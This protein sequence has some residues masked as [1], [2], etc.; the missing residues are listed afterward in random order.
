M[1]D[2]YTPYY[3]LRKQDPNTIADITEVNGNFDILDTT[4]KARADE[5]TALTSRVTSLESSPPGAIV[6][7]TC[8]PQAGFSIVAT[9]VRA[10]KRYGV[11]MF[12]ITLT[13]TGATLG[14]G[15]IGNL[16]MFQLNAAWKP[17]LPAM[18]H[19]SAYGGLGEAWLDNG[20]G[21]GV[22]TALGLA[23]T[24]NGT[25]SFCSTYILATP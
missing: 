4:V 11:A 22:L 25:F 1:A 19:N 16:N 15:N 8:T 5:I 9:N 21:W 3:N 24:Q 12:D 14:P 23:W 7:P 17:I 13:R 18:L 10:V 20:A 2:T 6:N